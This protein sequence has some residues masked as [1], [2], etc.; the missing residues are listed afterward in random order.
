VVSRW[1]QKPCLVQAWRSGGAVL[2]GSHRPRSQ[3]RRPRG[4]TREAPAS[5]A[6]G[7]L[8]PRLSLARSRRTDRP[9]QGPPVPP[10]PSR[11]REWRVR[12]LVEGLGSGRRP[13]ATKQP[14]GE[15]TLRPHQN[16]ETMI[17]AAV[18]ERLQRE[19]EAR[20]SR[21]KVTTHLSGPAGPGPVLAVQKCGAR[22]ADLSCPDRRPEHL[23]RLSK[24]S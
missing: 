18:E 10:V 19:C 17:Q 4:P 23:Y 22:G 11:V 13:V 5:Q 2:S 7:D 1:E 21:R 8:R 15:I 12:Q 24:L 6:S 20:A 3:A 16:I 9:I 14:N